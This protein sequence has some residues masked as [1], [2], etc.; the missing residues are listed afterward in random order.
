MSK[1]ATEKAIK[2]SYLKLAKIH[3]PDQATGDKEA[4]QKK[5]QEIAV[6]YE[7]LSDKASTQA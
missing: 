6:A 5:F 2:K 4:A 7:T 1:T 3:H